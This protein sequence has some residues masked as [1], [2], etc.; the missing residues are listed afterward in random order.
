MLEDSRD[1]LGALPLVENALLTLWQKREGNRLSGD[2]Y[3]G[4]NGIAGMLSTQADTLLAR[5][6]AGVPQGRQAA[7]EL[8]LRLTRIND[9]GRHTRERITRKEAVRIAGNGNDV[10]GE[11]VVRMLSGERALGALGATHN[12]ALRLIATSREELIADGTEQGT[13]GTEQKDEQ[14]VDL[15]HETLIRARGKDKNTGKPIGY[16]PTLYDYIDRNRDRELARRLKKTEIGIETR[17][18]QRRLSEQ[19]DRWRQSRGL[20]RW[21]RLAGS[22]DL[23][24]YRRMALP[25]QSPEGRFLALSRRVTAVHF[26]LLA[27]VGGVF[28]EAAWWKNENSLPLSYIV[29]R[30]LWMLGYNKPL[31]AMV[32]IKPGTFTMG[33]K[34]GHDEVGD[35][36]CGD[37]DRAHEVTLT[38]PFE[39][40]ANEVTFSE[41]D[42]Y[43]WDQGGGKGKEL[44]YP[45]DGGWGRD[46]RPGINV[47]WKDAK[48]YAEWLGKK[49]GKRCRLPTEAEWEYAARAGTD[50]AFWWGPQFDKDKANC[51]G[52]K[53]VPVNSFPKNRWDLRNTAGNVYEWVEDWYAAYPSEP[54][55]DPPGPPEGRS[56]VL[57]GGSWNLYPQGC[58]AAGRYSFG[59]DFRY[60]IIGF[61]VCC[62]S[63]IE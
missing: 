39:I 55:T 31:P 9:Q 30:P 3:R 7:L 15:I 10:N 45:F 28:A 59:P 22:R 41:Y 49:K 29:Q 1:E 53:P 37:D 25:K 6:E 43:V 50:T 42:Y 23:W 32:D 54:V 56:R 35:A 27:L 18:L 8:L 61:R 13:T 19:F 63:P 57:R 21:W 46:S 11:L 16:W 48:G 20:G 36:K 14:Y 17:R 2:E 34:P 33:C 40:G 58:R 47:S 44:V 24:R 52:D 5:I 51:A 12:A 38:K 60:H 26:G 62:S 4:Q